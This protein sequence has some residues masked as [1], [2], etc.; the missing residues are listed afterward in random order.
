MESFWQLIVVLIF[1]I[2]FLLANRKK[3]HTSTHDNNDEILPYRDHHRDFLMMP[4][5]D[6]LPENIYHH[7]DDD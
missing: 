4:G 1:G 5:Y 3:I 6:H 2:M 7:H